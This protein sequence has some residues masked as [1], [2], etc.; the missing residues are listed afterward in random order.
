MASAVVAARAILVDAFD[1][2]VHVAS[3]V[4]KTM[5]RRCI[6][7]SRAGGL[8]GRDLDVPR[9]LVECFASTAENAPDDVQA[10]QDAY[11]AHDA[12]A[13]A[14]NAGPWAG[15]YATGWKGDAIADFADPGQPSHARFQF[16]GLLYLLNN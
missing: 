4:P 5:P 14:S 3:K 8:R 16:T 6:R 2:A 12:L 7:I 10:E 1:S 9:L 13:A 15:V 11:A